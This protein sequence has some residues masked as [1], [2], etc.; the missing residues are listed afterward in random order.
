MAVGGVLLG[1]ALGG[2]WLWWDQVDAIYRSRVY[3]PLSTT[4]EVTATRAGPLLT[5]TIDDPRWGAAE[6]VPGAGLVPDHGKLMHMFLVQATDLS[7]FAHLHPTP[8][9]RESFAVLLPPLPPG[10]YR[11]FADIVQETGF[12]PTLVDT[13]RVPAAGA[14]GGAAPPPAPDV[15]PGDP[16]RDPDDSWAALRPHGASRSASGNL[17]SGRTMRWERD[18]PLAV[19]EETT[20]RFTVTEPDGSPSPLE[21]YMGMRSHAAV[22]RDDGAVFVHLHPAGSINLTAQMRFAVAEGAGGADGAVGAPAMGTMPGMPVHPA[23]AAA[24][25]VT[26]PFVFPEPGAYRIVVQ[27]K[28]DGTVETAA[29]DVDVNGAPAT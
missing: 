1:G 28:V 29:F 12:A 3:R 5:L 26:F 13:V 15:Q 10:E 8:V 16:V 17:P 2:G 19:D 14:D 21:P 9:S 20:L 25:A 11:I 23:S 6:G 27:V 4:A 18:D 22:V 7:A 24:N